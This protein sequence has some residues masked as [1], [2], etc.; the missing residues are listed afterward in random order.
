MPD[1]E[2]RRKL[3][4]FYAHGMTVAPAVADVVVKKTHKAS[5]ALIKELM[6][7]SAQYRLQSGNDG[8]LELSHVES[9]L[10]E[11]LFGGGSLN[12]KLLGG[13]VEG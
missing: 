9:A 10:E 6:R 13:Q 4:H 11:M 3:L 1:E 12:R 8:P 5:G 2:G 7:R